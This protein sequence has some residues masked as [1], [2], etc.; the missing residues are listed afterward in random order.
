MSVFCLP[1]VLTR[2]FSRRVLREPAGVYGRA[3]EPDPG[4]LLL[5]LRGGQ[6]RHGPL[7]TL[8]PG[9]GGRVF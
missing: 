3:G 7:G 6:A 9:G 2:I 4:S 5:R 1:N 8:H